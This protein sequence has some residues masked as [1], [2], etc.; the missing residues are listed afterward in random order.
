VEEV[1]III[2][3]GQRSRRIDGPYNIC[4]DIKS[5]RVLR[6]ALTDFIERGSSY[7]WVEVCEKAKILPNTPPEPWDASNVHISMRDTEN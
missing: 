1:Q 4:G 5:L 3:A 7:G 6:D 2:H